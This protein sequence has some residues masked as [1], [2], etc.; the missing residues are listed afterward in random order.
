MFA[1]LLM[2]FGVV[3]LAELGD[4]SQLMA[5]TFT[6]RYRWWVVLAGI[7]TAALSVHLLSAGI[8]H[9]LGGAL[10]TGIVTLVGGVVFVLF[11]LWTLR[12][13]PDAE[14]D[15]PTPRALAAPAFFA[16]AGTFVLAEL[17][18]KTMLATVTLSTDNNWL[19]V[20]IGSTLGMVVADALAIGVGALAGHHLPKRAIALVGA[21]LFLVFG[22]TMLSV[23]IVAAL[24]VA[25]AITTVWILHTR[26]T[27]V[28]P[29]ADASVA[30]DD[31]AIAT[32]RT[33]V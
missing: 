10:D 7:F 20:W 13:S 31:R 2:S 25:I 17:G 29:P 1:A 9:L 19:G 26:E 5:L 28:S 6:L 12:E 16:V 3:F 11:G 15:G 32:T 14:T 33:T 4:K 21:T 27:A 18:D 22:L 24:V 23:H 30:G 8:G